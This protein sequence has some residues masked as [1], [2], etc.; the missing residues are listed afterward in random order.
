[1]NVEEPRCGLIAVAVGLMQRLLPNRFLAGVHLLLIEVDLG[2]LRRANRIEIRHAV[3]EATLGR[4]AS[5]R[6]SPSINQDGKFNLILKSFG[7][8]GWLNLAA[9]AQ[10][11]LPNDSVEAIKYF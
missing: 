4:M 9:L 5:G 10:A 8:S 7:I 2:R 11:L 3:P 1:M 6:V